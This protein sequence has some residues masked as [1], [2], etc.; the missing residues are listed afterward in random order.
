MMLIGARKTFAEVT[1]PSGSGGSNTVQVRFRPLVKNLSNPV[2]SVLEIVL[3]NNT[4]Y[5]VI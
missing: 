3:F 4:F 2:L 5:E 1:L